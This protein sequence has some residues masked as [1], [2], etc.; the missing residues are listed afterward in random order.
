VVTGG[1]VAKTREELAGALR[2]AWERAV[3]E[4][5]LPGGGLPAFVVEVPRE[6]EHGDF[7]SNLAMLLA[8]TARMNPRRIA[9][10]LAERL[11][12]GRLPLMGLEVAGP[13]FINFTLR[14]G[15]VLAAL[16]QAVSLG[17]D[18]G[19]VDLGRGARV[20]VE[21][22]SANPTG[23]L[24]MGNARGGALGDSL[25]AL[26]SFA[27][28]RVE[29]EFYINDAG[30]QIEKLAASLEA[31]YRQVLGEAAEVPGDGYHGLDLLETAQRFAAR[32]ER[33]P[34]DAARRRA[35]TRF[36]LDEKLA[37]IRAMLLRFGVRYDR[38]FPESELHETGQVA[39]VIRRL[40]EAG[41]AYRGDGALWLAG[42]KLGLEK[43]E[44]LVRSNGVPTYFAADIAYHVNKMERGFDRVIDIWGADHHGHVARLKA[45][46]AALGFDAEA[47]TVIIIQLVRL[48]Q[49]GEIVRMSK[50]TGKYVTLEELVDEV[51][52]DAA[53]YFFV[54]RS[55]ESHLDFDLDLARRQSNDNPVY[56]IQ[57]AHAR[58]CSIFRQW[59]E[60]TPQWGG[61]DVSLLREEAELAL[62]RQIAWF[63]EEIALAAEQLAPHRLARYAHELA[64][65]LHSFY[66]SHRVITD[67]GALTRARL[68]LMEATRV[69]LRSA[70]R[71][72]GI[73][74]P[75]KM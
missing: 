2:R 64:G 16:P 34:D 27:G 47:L 30:L 29:R 75:E 28:Y 67:D 60:D 21:F 19:R 61:V 52:A 42:R 38:W 12:A 31:R 71:L 65:L 36:G 1:V 63:P 53:R 56:Y 54:L 3:A 4:G 17:A 11:D 46:L 44:V 48:F 24:H 5:V 32:G 74:A 55:A 14:P 62:A 59:G 45:A 50:R 72:I 15:W 37:A 13:G 26:L 73:N 18:Y 39:D 8:G 9:G 25:A 41:A 7:A 51:G 68:M 69:V 6:R 57:Y 40:E 35:L 70:C 49:G 43:D 23:L 20:Q 22:V 10:L 66:N 33:F 58:I